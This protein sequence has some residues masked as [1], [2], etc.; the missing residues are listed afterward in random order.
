MNS[1]TLPKLLSAL[2]LSVGSCSTAVAIAW[3]VS[4]AGLAEVNCSNVSVTLPNLG[5]NSLKCGPTIACTSALVSL[6]SSIA[7]YRLCT[8][9]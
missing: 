8:A 9:V 5:N 4:S 2:A 1:L 6:S 7:A 3:A